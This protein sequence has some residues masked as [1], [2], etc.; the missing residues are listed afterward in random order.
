[1]PV[2]AHAAGGG[3]AVGQ[4][5]R[6]PE[7]A[8][9]QALRITVAVAGGMVAT[10]AAGSPLSF[11][12]P[13]FAAQ[14]LAASRSPPR[15]AQAVGM[16]VLITGV[17]QAM[18]M[19]LA[20]AL[21]GERPAVFVPLLWLFYFACFLAQARGGK[22]GQAAS[23]VL[24]VSVMVPLM[25][26]LRLDLG[27]SMAAILAGVAAGVSC[28]LGQRTWP[29]PIPEACPRRRRRRPWQPAPICTVR[30]P[31]RRS[32]WPLSSSASWTAGFL[33]WS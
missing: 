25:G 16:V 24:V 5:M 26:T 10:A 7:R 32:F 33:R 6:E 14:F 29:S 15:P 4:V 2:E 20:V 3:V 8:R 22:A 17:G 11:L 9:R 21:L 30:P 31:A 18:A 1:M 19:A 12:A 28:S 27:S 23:L 13:L